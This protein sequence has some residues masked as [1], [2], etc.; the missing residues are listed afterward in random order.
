MMKSRKSFKNIVRTVVN[1]KS[2]E[3]YENSIGR[4]QG[5]PICLFFVYRFFFTLFKNLY[6]LGKEMLI[7]LKF[8]CSNETFDVKKATTINYY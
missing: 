3:A 7:Y 6:V 5:Y 2:T 8:I 4:S 1:P